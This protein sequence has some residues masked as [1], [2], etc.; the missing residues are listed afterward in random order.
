MAKQVVVHALTARGVISDT[1]RLDL[2]S[3]SITTDQSRHIEIWTQE[4]WSLFP[5]RG[6]ANPCVTVPCPAF[7]APPEGGGW[8]APPNVIMHDVDMFVE[9]GTFYMPD[10]RA[11][12][13]QGMLEID[14]KDQPKESTLFDRE[15]INEAYEFLADIKRGEEVE[16]ILELIAEWGDDTYAPHT[17][18]RFNKEF[19]APSVT[20]CNGVGQGFP[21]KTYTYAV[22]KL[23]DGKWASAGH[24]QFADWDAFVKFLVTEGVPVVKED[25]EIFPPAVFMRTDTEVVNL[26]EMV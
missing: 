10:W 5:A 8:C 4:E 16:Q 12:V 15:S 14:T 22:L 1:M 17:V 18:L 9:P 13:F 7:P 19:D 6:L 11:G 21:A 2:N 3:V 23:D 25:V 26:G 24:T 20:G